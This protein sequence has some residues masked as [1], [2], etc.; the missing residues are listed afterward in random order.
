MTVQQRNLGLGR[1]SKRIRRP[2]MLRF[3]TVRTWCRSMWERL[4]NTYY[5]QSVEHSHAHPLIPYL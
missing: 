1:S 5:N 4:L 2:P 3:P